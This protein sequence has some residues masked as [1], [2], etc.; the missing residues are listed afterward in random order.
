MSKDY[1]LILKQAIEKHVETKY[2]HVIPPA[3]YITPFG[4]KTVD[5]LLGG[6][7]QSSSPICISSTPE[8]GKSTTSL[9]FASIFLRL[10]PNSVVIYIN[11]EEAIGSTS[12]EVNV[13]DNIHERISSFGIDI[14]RFVNKPVELNVKE[15]FELISELV[16][17]KR[18]I[19][20][21]T[22]QEQKLLIIWDSIAATQSSKDMSA[23]D[24]KEVIGYKARE[25]THNLA[26]YK[27]YIS[28]ERVT[29]IIIDQVRS[30]IQVETPWARAGQE[31]SI[32]VFGNYKSATSVSAFQHNVRQWIFLSKGNTLK[33]SD[34]MKV[35]GWELNFYTEKNKLAPSQYSVPLV[36]DKKWG[37][38]PFYSEYIFLK[39][40]TKTERKYWPTKDLI[41][42]FCIQ[43][44][45]NSKILTV[46]DPDTK[47]ILYKSSKVMESK[48][49]ERYNTDQEFRYW[50][51]RAVDISV[52]QRIKVALFR[53]TTSSNITIP[54]IEINSNDDVNQ[55]EPI[56]DNVSSINDENTVGDYNMIDE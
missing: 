19:E 45:G 1:T 37:I 22:G 47:N 29:F 6:G 14:N 25:L 49:L 10:Y 30:N 42:P 56:T 36:F 31:K 18:K 40:K 51:D 2:G 38:I 34:P 8:T 54:E 3:P 20:E 26:R 21:K 50:F 53:E 55:C 11:I 16:Q 24:P 35:D 43:S 4:I 46:I 13:N 12:A 9:Q 52:E 44:E 41:Y 28:M 39:D 17:L 7:F 5:T 27:S 23:E 48:I 33:P 32:G 15:V